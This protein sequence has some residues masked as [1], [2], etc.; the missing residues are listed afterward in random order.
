[1]KE[2]NY[3]FFKNRITYWLGYATNNFQNKVNSINFS[4]AYILRVWGQKFSEINFF[5]ILIWSMNRFF[6][7]LTI[8]NWTK[9][10]KKLDQRIFWMK[11]RKISK[12]DQSLFYESIFDLK[13]HQLIFNLTLNLF[14]FML[15][16]FLLLKLFSIKFLWLFLSYINN[17]HIWP[18]ESY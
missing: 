10:N 12:G 13:L 16:I 8:F 14:N 3:H 18:N 9:N 17:F 15:N 7:C 5:S 11:L 6:D 1:M 2:R 4:N